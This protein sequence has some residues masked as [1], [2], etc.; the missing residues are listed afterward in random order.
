MKGS[1]EVTGRDHFLFDCYIKE[2]EMLFGL[3]CFTIWFDAQH[4]HLCNYRI[5]GT[6]PNHLSCYVLLNPSCFFTYKH[7][8]YVLKYFSKA[9]AAADVPVAK[10][11]TK[12]S[13]SWCVVT[14]LAFL[15]VNHTSDELC[16]IFWKVARKQFSLSANPHKPFTRP[17]PGCVTLLRLIHCV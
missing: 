3:I 11:G 15:P 16:E 17:W 10:Y 7:T 13:T 2:E 9:C 1:A 12:S 6:R 5:I 14:S 4:T 8:Q